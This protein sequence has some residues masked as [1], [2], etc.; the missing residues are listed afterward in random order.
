MV[1]SSFIGVR[2]TYCNV[3]VPLSFGMYTR[4]MCAFCRSVMLLVAGRHTAGPAAARGAAR[5][6]LRA[7]P[8]VRGL[9]AGTFNHLVQVGQTSLHARILS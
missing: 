1:N 9:L 4:S 7:V 2:S 8:G 3:S 5:P 6:D